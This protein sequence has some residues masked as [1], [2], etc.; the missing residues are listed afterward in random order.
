V[1]IEFNIDTVDVPHLNV[2][3]RSLC[4]LDVLYL[5][6]HPQTPLLKESGVV[7][8]TQPHGCERFR[9]VPEV[10]AAGSGDCDQLA[11]WRA[12]ELRVRHGVKALPEVRR[13]AVGLWHVYVRLPNGAVE[14]ISA[15]L[16][17][18]VPA[19]LARIGRAIIRARKTNPHA[20]AF[21]SARASVF[22]DNA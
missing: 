12:A 2:L 5:R 17:M 1:L 22:G 9:T 8:K 18:P 19:S 21:D 13:M 3:V 7:Y 14:D 6:A 16:G 4:A 15:H 11:P 20:P 10:I